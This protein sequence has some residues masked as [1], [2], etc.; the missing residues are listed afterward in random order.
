MEVVLIFYNK[1][2][3]VGA[4]ALAIDN[5]YRYLFFFLLVISAKIFKISFI[6]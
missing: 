2:L 6:S 1:F 4:T 5:A 3:Q